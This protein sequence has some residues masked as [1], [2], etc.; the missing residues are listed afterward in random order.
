MIMLKVH[1]K[2]YK[3]YKERDIKKFF[4]IPFHRKIDGEQ[5]VG[6]KLEFFKTLNLKKEN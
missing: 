6:M 4:Y 1:K 2:L 5:I 3:N